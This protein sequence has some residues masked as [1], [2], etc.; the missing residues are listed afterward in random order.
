MYMYVTPEELRKKR[1]ML[2]RKNRKEPISIPVTLTLELSSKKDDH[3]LA[4][5]SSIL[6][7]GPYFKKEGIY[8]K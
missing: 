4:A 8:N 7:F 5:N 1:F 3:F 6:N 2:N